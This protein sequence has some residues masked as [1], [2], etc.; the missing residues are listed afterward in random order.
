[1]TKWD[2]YWLAWLG[3]GFLVPEVYALI[4]NYKNTLSETTW[5][6]FGVMKNEPLNHWSVQHYVLMAFMA[7]LFCHMVFRIFR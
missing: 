7:W 4:T 5:R 2:W 3:V 6:W 1:M